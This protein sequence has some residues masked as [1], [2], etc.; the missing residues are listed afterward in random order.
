MPT[1]EATINDWTEEKDGKKTTKKG[2]K[3]SADFDFGSD[4]DSMVEIFGENIV[5]KQ[6]LGALTVAAQ[7]GLRS[8]FKQGKTPQQITEWAKTWKPGERKAGKSPRE[9]LMEQLA[10]MSAEERAALLREAASTKAPAAPAAAT[11]KGKKA[12]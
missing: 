12:A 9:K 6:A 10:S 4:L 1:V 3:A 7:G 8:Q 11:G 2:G 5:Y